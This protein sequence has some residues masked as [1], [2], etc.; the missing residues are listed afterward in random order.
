MG[1]VVLNTAAV[2]PEGYIFIVDFDKMAVRPLR[3]LT[4]FE[5]AKTSDKTTY[6]MLVSTRSRYGTVHLWATTESTANGSDAA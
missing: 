6:M 1:E 3:P 2:L 5:V 4:M